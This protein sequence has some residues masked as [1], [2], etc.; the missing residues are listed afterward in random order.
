[1]LESVF[2]T[3]L[4]TLGTLFSTAIRAVAV[5]NLVIPD[6][7]PSTSFILALRKVLVANIVISSHYFQHF[8]QHYLH[9]S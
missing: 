1:M 5:A 3:K 4:L 7:Y 2:V 9:L 8:S 6:I